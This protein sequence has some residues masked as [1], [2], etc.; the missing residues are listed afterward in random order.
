MFALVHVSH[1]F[2]RLIVKTDEKEKGEMIMHFRPNVLAPI[3]YPTKCCVNHTCQETIV[4]HIH[5]SHTTN[6]N[7]H[8]FKHLHYYPHTQS[9]ENEVMNQHFNCGPVPP[10]G[11]MPPTGMVPQAGMGPQAGPAAPG[12][13]AQQN[14]YFRR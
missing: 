10:A 2:H 3:V 6:V 4:P 5:P 14:P 13:M 7:H 9:A 11:M 1:F 12:P 8:M